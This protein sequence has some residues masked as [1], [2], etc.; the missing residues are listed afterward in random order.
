MAEDTSAMQKALTTTSLSVSFITDTTPWLDRS[1]R[2]MAAT[3][4]ASK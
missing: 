1:F 4:E 2:S 3:A